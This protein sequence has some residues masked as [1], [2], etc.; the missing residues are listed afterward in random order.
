M[1]QRPV[2]QALGLM[3]EMSMILVGLGQVLLVM[4][5]LALSEG[6]MEIRQVNLD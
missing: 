1:R 5:L 2:S 4:E 3:G 6:M